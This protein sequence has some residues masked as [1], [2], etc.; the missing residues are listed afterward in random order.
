MGPIV[1]QTST[2][3]TNLIRYLPILSMIIA[4]ARAI[5]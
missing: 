2:V 4:A 5:K 3:D 1:A